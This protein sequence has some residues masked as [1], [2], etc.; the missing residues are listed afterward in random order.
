M[1]VCIYIYIYE[2]MFMY[3]RVC[4]CFCVCVFLCVPVC[5]YLCRLNS[6]YTLT[7]NHLSRVGGGRLLGRRAHPACDGS[8]PPST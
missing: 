5:V 1:Y 3:V 2:Y 4:V 7:D 6:G 8:V